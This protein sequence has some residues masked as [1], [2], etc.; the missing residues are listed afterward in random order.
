MRNRDPWE[1]ALGQIREG[2]I[3]MRRTPPNLEMAKNHLDTSELFLKEAIE[4]RMVPDDSA[5]KAI[6]KRQEEL[7]I[8]L[9]DMI[10][11]QE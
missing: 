1:D 10:R 5:H 2:E 3:E 7:R 9:R 4:W 6:L 11:E 8:R